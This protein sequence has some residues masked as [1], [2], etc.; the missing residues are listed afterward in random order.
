MKTVLIF[1]CAAF[2]L[3]PAA[4]WSLD[5]NLQFPQTTSVISDLNPANANFDVVYSAGP[6][7]SSDGLTTLG[8]WM[9]V[10]SRNSPGNFNYFDC[11][12]VFAPGSIYYKQVLNF[13][14]AVQQGTIVAGDGPF[15]G[16]SGSIT[17]V[18]GN[19]FRLSVTMP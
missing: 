10:V 6:V 16:I 2:I 5:I 12:M 1:L 17:P 3:I 8:N 9:C 14:T 19:I 18:S 4:A 7:K 15:Q 11:V 13:G